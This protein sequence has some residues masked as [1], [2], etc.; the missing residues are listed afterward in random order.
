MSTQPKPI[1]HIK[2]WPQ[3]EA[4]L[5]QRGSLTVWFSEDAVEH[6]H[7][8]TRTG[9]RGA[10]RTYSDWA[11]QCALTVQAVFGLP[12]RA[13]EG[14][15]GSLMGLLNLPLTVPD[16]TT[17][18]RRRQT[19]EVVIG[20]TPAPRARH[21][22]V[23]STGLKV[24][25]EGEWHVRQHGASKRRTWRKLH[26]G[27]DEASQEIV[28][29]LVTTNGVG[30]GEVLPELL[31]QIEGGIEQVSA[32]GSYDTRTCHEAIRHRSARAA[33]PPRANAQPWPAEVDGSPHPRTAILA[34]IA[35]QGRAQWKQA[36]GY[37][38]RS[39][40]ETAMFRLKTIFGARLTARLFDS[41]VAEGYIRC[42]A[43]NVMTRLGMPQSYRVIA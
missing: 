1:Y 35:A 37:H 14:F 38:R 18:S 19:L 12:L 15:L 11:I 3:Y 42:A 29:T 43:L 9:K 2:N 26:L 24:Y 34:A 10:S 30:D 8:T 5:V 17:L 28:A 27:V 20:R 7:E 39:L 22:V 36:A 33:I 25:G 16:H 41:Q 40:A 21:V 13:A 4:A 31:E 32:D 23:D 6:W